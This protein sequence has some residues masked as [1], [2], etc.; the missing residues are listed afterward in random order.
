LLPAQKNGEQVFVIATDTAPVPA[1]SVPYNVNGPDIT[2]PDLKSANFD[3]SGTTVTGEAEANS[4]ITVKDANGNVIGTA[5]TDATGH[6]AVVFNKPYGLGEVVKVTAIDAAGNES[7]PKDAIAPILTQA[8]NDVAQADLDLGYTSK[9]SS[10]SETKY[11]GSVVKFLGIP[12]LGSRCTEINFNVGETQKTNVDI[13]ATN[14]GLK[15]LFDGVRVTLYKQN[16]DGSWAKVVSNTDVGLFNKFFLFF[17]EQARIST[18]DLTQ[19]NYKI[20]AEDLTLFSIFSKNVLNVKYTT[21]TQS[22]DLAV[23]KANVLQ[24]DVLANDVGTDKVVTKITNTDGK[25]IDV[26]AAGATLVGK[27]GTI[28]IKADGSYKYTPN[29]D[30][31]ALGKVD[32]FSYTI[33]D[34]NGNPST[35][36]VFVQINSDEVK[37]EW[38]PN[39]PS[40]PAKTLNLKNDVDTVHID[41]YKQ[42]SISTKAVNSGELVA[43]TNKASAVA[44]NTFTVGDKS[45]STIK[46]SVKAGFD[47][48]WTGAKISSWQDASDTTFVWQLQRYNDKTG[49]WENVAGQSGSKTYNKYCNV[50]R[51]GT[52]L[53]SADVKATEPGQYRVNFSTKTGSFGGFG[54]QEFDTN[55]TVT[56]KTLTDNWAQNE[57][58]TTSGNIFTGVGTDSALVDSLGIFAKKLSI[59]VDGGATFTDVT[60]SSTVQGLYGKLAINANGDYTYTQTSNTLASDNFIYKVTTANGEFATASLK[61]GF[62]S[63]IH[64]TAQADTIALSDAIKNVLTLGAGSD[65][66][67]YSVLNEHKDAA[68]I[69]TD[70]SKAEGDKID[71]SQLLSGQS[72]NAGNISNYLSVSQNGNATVVKIDQ[73]GTGTQYAPKEL[74]I[75]QNN[76]LSLD[77]LLQGGHII[78]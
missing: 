23:L 24:G 2:P 8:N 25:S 46:V 60:S 6:Y 57:N 7:L 65:I 15:S 68:D 64:G 53:F 71:V 5:T 1:T 19:G 44:S 63:T 78:Y 20:I 77:D 41:I 52:E 54:G 45:E 69:W 27:Y 66:I 26:T 62:E 34:G 32:E 39:D 55:V 67:K 36:K 3:A 18:K 12:V 35:A 30:I 49:Q 14:F 58:G 4:K 33:K 61:I 16:T 73:D 76:H 10:Y 75:L 74:I 51:T 43:T 70:F 56:T 59:S 28:V 40:K 13:T 22:T 37:L 9:T 38:D 29:K 21:E 11:F 50:L 17:P 31:N 47:T 42:T 72:V 48:T